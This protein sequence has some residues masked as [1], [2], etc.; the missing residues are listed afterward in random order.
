MVFVCLLIS[1]SSLA[2]TAGFPCWLGAG[3]LWL[4]ADVLLLS[5]CCL[6]PTGRWTQRLSAGCIRSSAPHSQAGREA[7]AP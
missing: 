6:V 4:S 5:Y 1:S 7:I 2:V 3:S